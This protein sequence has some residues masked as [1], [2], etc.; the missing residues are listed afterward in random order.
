MSNDKREFL[1]FFL[2]LIEETYV[3]ASD[4]NIHTH[5]YAQNERNEAV[6]ITYSNEWENEKSEEKILFA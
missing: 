4:V 6:S 5:T 3:K 1:L 2:R